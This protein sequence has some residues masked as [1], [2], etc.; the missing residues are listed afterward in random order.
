VVNVRSN[1]VEG[2]WRRHRQ[3]SIT[4]ANGRARL[5]RWRRVNLALLVAG[6]VLGAVAAQSSWPRGLTATAGGLAAFALALAAIV[7]QRFL[8]ANEVARWTGAR[9]AS[10]ALK[11]EVFRYLAGVAPYDGAGRDQA[12]NLRV[13]AVR[14]KA[15]ALMV[16]VQQI[17]ADDR[18]LPDV[19]D[20]ASYV[21]KRAKDQADWHRRK[22][23]EHVQAARRIRYAELAATVIA[24]LLGAIGAALDTKGLAVWIG[25]ATTIGAAFAA[26]LSATQHDRI[27]A[28]Y[29]T[30][31]DRLD[32]LIEQLPAEPDA[33]TAAQFVADVE[34]RL[35]TQNESWLGLF[36]ATI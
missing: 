22:I 30:T 36:S 7:Q 10:E 33:A 15:D 27:A 1:A 25:V 17:P 12:L 2:T 6:A 13:D 31:A 16:D 26:H 5:D 24:A 8:N 29:A 18:A 21:A 9:A 35:A 3:W 28:T 32:L 20:L 14:D 19:H 4:A 34:S 23:G 11:A